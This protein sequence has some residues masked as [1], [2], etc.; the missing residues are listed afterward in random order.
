M[1]FVG[2]ALSGIVPP[3]VVSALLLTIGWWPFRRR[4]AQ[5]PR[6]WAAPLALGLGTLSACVVLNGWPSLALDVEFKHGLAYVA[7]VG[8]GL[9]CFEASRDRRARTTWLLRGVACV[10]SPFL[11]LDFAREHQWG[12]VEGWLWTGG[13]ALAL[14]GLLKTWDAMARQRTGAL[15]PTVWTIAAGASGAALHLAGS[16]SFGQIAGALATSLGVAAAIALLRPDFTL[17]RGAVVPFGLLLT[18]L[19]FGGVFASELPRAA[20]LALLAASVLPG[21]VLGRIGP[22]R[23]LP[24]WI[25]ALV[26]AFAPTAWPLWSLWTESAASPY[27]AYD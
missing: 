11:L 6:A 26:L 3:L 22:A 4:D 14:M 24:R 9:G 7:A 13:L 1:D 25:A 19:L 18:A 15:L 20:A 17:V 8:A 16:S 2:I 12:S 23:T 10:A 27:A 5:A 21:L